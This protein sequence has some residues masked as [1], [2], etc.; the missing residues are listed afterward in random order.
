MVKRPSIIFG[1]YFWSAF[2]LHAWFSLVQMDC[3]SMEIMD[4]M[5]Y[6]WVIIGRDITKM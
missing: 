1:F 4:R 2:L 5:Y 6:Y 3:K